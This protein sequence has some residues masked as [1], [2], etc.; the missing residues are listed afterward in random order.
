MVSQGQAQQDSEPGCTAGLLLLQRRREREPAVG[1]GQ[2]EAAAGAGLRLRSA[3]HFPALWKPS[4]VQQHP[5]HLSRS[6][7]GRG[8]AC[9]A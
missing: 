7:S 8:A 4:R 2:V 9:A 3:V 5:L 1:L 6:R